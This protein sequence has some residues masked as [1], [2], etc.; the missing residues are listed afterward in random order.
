MSAIKVNTCGV[1][2]VIA[3]LSWSI[4]ARR[5]SGK[6][7]S[8]RQHVMYFDFTYSCC[9]YIGHSVFGCNLLS[10]KAPRGLI[11]LLACQQ[12]SFCQKFYFWAQ[13]H[14]M[15]QQGL[16]VQEKQSADLSLCAFP[17]IWLP[18]PCRSFWE[19]VSSWVWASQLL[20]LFCLCQPSELECLWTWSLSRC[21]SHNEQSPHIG[22]WSKLHFEKLFLNW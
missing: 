2:P 5:Y 3:F 21:S 12:S 18:S 22:H 14:W 20:A 17:R 7:E 6:S 8:R 15:Y 1:K 13:L 4:L 11:L 10:Q 19:H 16:G 9:K